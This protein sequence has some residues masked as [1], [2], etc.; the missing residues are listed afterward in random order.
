MHEA[1]KI[2]CIYEFN[3]NSCRQLAE[4][5]Q[6]QESATFRNMGQGKAV[7]TKYKRLKLGGG[8]TY[9]RSND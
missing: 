3:I 5:I 8:Q 2:P 7:H 1:F 4:V 6:N 9:D